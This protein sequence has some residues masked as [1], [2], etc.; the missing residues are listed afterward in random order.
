VATDEGANLM[1]WGYNMTNMGWWMVISSIIWLGL[2][3]IAVWAFAR[4]ATHPPQQTTSTPLPA[5]EILRQRFARG[6][7]DSDTFEH[8]RQQLEAAPTEQWTPANVS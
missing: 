6:E 1:M 7:I 8:M 5:T 2:I 4:W 3:A